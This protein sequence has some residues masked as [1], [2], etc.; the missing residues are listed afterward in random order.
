MGVCKFWVQPSNWWF[1]LKSTHLFVGFVL[2]IWILYIN[3]LGLPVCLWCD[4]L[5]HN[6][7][8]C[9]CCGTGHREKHF[10]LE[11]APPGNPFDFYTIVRLSVCDRAFQLVNGLCDADSA[12]PQK[13]AAETDSATYLLLFLSFFFYYFSK[14]SKATY[15]LLFLSF[16]F[17][18]FFFGFFSPSLKLT[19]MKKKNKK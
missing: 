9:F 12:T 1:V 8:L 14:K 17:G 7:F 2:K 10:R 4:V 15:L 6:H 18:F 19:K 11:L 3:S 13:W 16:F 5:L